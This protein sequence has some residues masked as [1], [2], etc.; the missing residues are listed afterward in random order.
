MGWQKT[1]GAVKSENVKFDKERVVGMIEERKMKINFGIGFVTGRKNFRNLIKTYINNWNEQGLVENVTISLNLFIAYDLKYADT[2]ET[3]Y[4]NLEPELLTMV[5]TVNYIDGTLLFNEKKR[6]IENGTVTLAE[7]ALI[8]G[9]G[10]AKKRNAVMYFALKNKMDY[11]LFID[12]DE[13]PVAPLK[14]GTEELIWK[15]QNVLGTHLK[16]IVN[17]GITHGYHCG[18]ISPIPNFNFNSILSENDFKIFIEAVSND[19]ISWNSVKSKMENGGVTLADQRLLDSQQVY[20][21]MEVKGAK[22]ISGSNL[23]LNLN[24]A[25]QIAPFYNPPGARGEDTFLSTCLQRL[26]VIK[27]PCYTFHDGF[28]SYPHLLQG[29]LPSVLK[30]VQN[31][32]KVIQIRFLKAALGWVRYKPLLLYIT[33][34]KKYFAEIIRIEGQLLKVIPKLCRYFNNEEFANIYQEF[35]RYHRLVQRHYQEFEATKA[36]WRKLVLTFQTGE[37]PPFYKEFMRIEQ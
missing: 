34:P 19:I 16:H 32:S 37:E 5:D 28:L 6:L 36:A 1:S 4:R 29:V 23:C 9:E 13:Y 24:K 2:K 25:E 30:P 10:Y 27:V 20:E 14:S 15:G 12:D 8:F 35:I 33:R 18:Y 11:L 7:A 3:D 17:A 31:T 21:V 26:K 22:F